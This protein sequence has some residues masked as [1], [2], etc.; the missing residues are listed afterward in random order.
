MFKHMLSPATSTSTSAYFGLE[1][2]KNLLRTRELRAI[3]PRG[4]TWYPGRF[5]LT[6]LT[7]LMGLGCR[8]A[9]LADYRES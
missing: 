7:K 2:W 3:L 4:F 1:I 6:M 5:L 8:F 9:K